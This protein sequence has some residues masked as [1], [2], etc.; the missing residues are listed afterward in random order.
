MC[1]GASCKQEAKATSFS[2]R[3]PSPWGRFLWHKFTYQLDVWGGPTLWSPFCRLRF[4]Y[5]GRRWWTRHWWRRPCC[6][7]TVGIPGTVWL[8][9][10]STSWDLA[11]GKSTSEKQSLNLLNSKAFCNFFKLCYWIFFLKLRIFKR[12]DF[13]W[14][15]LATS[16]QHIWPGLGLEEFRASCRLV[17]H[18]QA[19][20]TQ[21]DKARRCQWTL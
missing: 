13:E 6:F 21:D 14:S 4:Y 17:G 5:Q 18:C 3:L 16:H 20:S 8:A 19:W 11:G 15:P 10:Q 1:K 9:S 2:Y 7:L 12:R